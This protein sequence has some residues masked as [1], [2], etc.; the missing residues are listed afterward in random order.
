MKARIDRLVTNSKTV[1]TSEDDLADLVR[2]QEDW[3]TTSQSREIC[4]EVCSKAEMHLKENTSIIDNY[5]MGDGVQFM[6]STDVNII[7]GTNRGLWV[8]DEADQWP[9]Q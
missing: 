4:R 7:R 2:L 8:E 3:E 1:I 5:A 9:P 6:V